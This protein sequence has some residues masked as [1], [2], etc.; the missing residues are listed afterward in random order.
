MVDLFDNKNEESDPLIP[1]NIIKRNLKEA[2]T[3]VA[4]KGGGDLN[5]SSSDSD[6]NKIPK[7]T[8][9]GRGVVA[10]KIINLAFEHDV[11]VRQD[12]ELSEILSIIELD[13]PI[14]SEAF[15]AVAEILS[16]IYE[17]KVLK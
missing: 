6:I 11:K 16:Y 8:A 9:A 13:S 1:L 4:L 7:I 14:P 17:K 10:E 5:F 12:K 15:M 3:A 2:A